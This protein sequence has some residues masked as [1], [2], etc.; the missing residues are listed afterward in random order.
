MRG[1]LRREEF[2]SYFYGRRYK[3]LFLPLHAWE[4]LLGCA[5]AVWLT[6]G[7]LWSVG[8]ALGYGHHLITDHLRNAGNPA[9]YS[10]LYRASHGFRRSAF[11][12][13]G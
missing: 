1:R 3:R 13:D 6:G 5:G 7:A 10:I 4:W 8:L 9:G 2:F 12:G 11:L